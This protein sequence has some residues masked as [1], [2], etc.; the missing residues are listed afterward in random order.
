MRKRAPNISKI[1]RM[2]GYKPRYRLG[3]IIADVAEYQKQRASGIRLSPT[4]SVKI[5]NIGT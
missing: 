2:I 3:D 4:Y 5:G 1:E